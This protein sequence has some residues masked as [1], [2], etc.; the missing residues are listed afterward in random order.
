MICSLLYFIEC[1]FVNI[2]NIFK[3]SD[4]LKELKQELLKQDRRSTF[5]VKLCRVHLMF[6]PP[7]LFEQSNTISLE[8][9]FRI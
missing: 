8:S 4:I 1:I 9:A 6:I 5:N 2:L 7:R 3:L